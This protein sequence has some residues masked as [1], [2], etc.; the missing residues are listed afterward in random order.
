MVDQLGQATPGLPSH[1]DRSHGASVPGISVAGPMTPQ[2]ERKQRALRRGLLEA[3]ALLDHLIEERE[4]AEQG[5]H[6]DEIERRFTYHQPRGNQAEI[7]QEL[8]ER[9]KSLALF[10]IEVVPTSREQSLALTHL[11]E[12]IFYAN[13]GIARRTPQ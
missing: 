9:A 13:A 2:E 1:R 10:I 11:E 5:V 6:R 4:M 12:A 3:V 8:R 7:Y